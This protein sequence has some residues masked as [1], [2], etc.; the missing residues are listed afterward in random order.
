M[1]FY[2]V[3]GTYLL[4]WNEGTWTNDGK[5]HITMT[6]RTSNI[7][8]RHPNVIIPNSKY[9]I[10]LGWLSHELSVTTPN[11]WVVYEAI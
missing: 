10:R 6:T 2:P 11:A 3:A 9:S 4:P 7:T 5:G 1:N 8:Y